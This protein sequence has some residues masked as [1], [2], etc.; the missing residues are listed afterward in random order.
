MDNDLYDLT[1]EEAAL[2]LRN[3]A[4]RPVYEASCRGDENTSRQG[5]AGTAR[6][7]D[8]TRSACYQETLT[9]MMRLGTAPY[10]GRLDS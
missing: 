8:P 10:L 1:K 2:M 4:F 3:T 7:N 5:G 6:S 9:T